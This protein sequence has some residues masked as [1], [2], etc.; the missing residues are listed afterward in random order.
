MVRGRFVLHIAVLAMAF[1]VMSASAWGD[2]V[3]P[4]SGAT[5]TVWKVCG[6]WGSAQATAPLSSGGGTTTCNGTT[7]STSTAAVDFLAANASEGTFNTTNIN[8][9]VPSGGG[10]LSD[11]LTNGSAGGPNGNGAFTSYAGT[12]SGA[13][14]SNCTAS[15]FDSGA[16]DGC[17]STVIEIKGNITLFPG[18]YTVLHDDGA[19][20]SL[21]GLGT[22]INSASP[23]STISST[24]VYSGASGNN[25][26]FD[27]WYMGTNT[28]PEELQLMGP[29]SVPE[30]GTILLLVI[31]L[32]V[33]GGFLLQRQ[34]KTNEG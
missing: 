19:I 10:F 17:Y 25:V 26:T 4:V 11:F 21:G 31:N 12:G 1:L 33:V 2:I 34:L 15:S 13:L 23:T 22:V 14:M 18:T 24:Y 29:T 16:G 5:G 20:L 32:L 3:V 27:L 6:N 9:Y 28:N 8:F 7:Q 30:A